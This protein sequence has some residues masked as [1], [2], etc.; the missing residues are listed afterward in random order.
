[1]ELV[2][3]QPHE[4]DSTCAIRARRIN[5]Q[6]YIRPAL[7]SGGVYVMELATPREAYCRAINLVFQFVPLRS[8]VRIGHQVER[9]Y[10]SRPNDTG[11]CQI[12]TPKQEARDRHKYK[13][14]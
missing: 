4:L 3:C 6:L 13:V 2:L 12:P 8:Y 1:M 11:C 14:V 5:F 10:K 9:A 7:G